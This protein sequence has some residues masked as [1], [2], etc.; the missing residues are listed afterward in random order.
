[1]SETIRCPTT[2]PSTAASG[3]KRRRQSIT[4]HDATIVRRPQRPHNVCGYG[5][6]CKLCGATA[7]SQFRAHMECVFDWITSLTVRVRCYYRAECDQL[8]SRV[9]FVVLRVCSHGWHSGIYFEIFV[10]NNDKSYNCALRSTI[11]YYITPNVVQITVWNS[12]LPIA[13][14]QKRRI[15]D[16][17]IPY[18]HVPFSQANR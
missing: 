18:K 8:L 17:E 4:T 12:L 6:Q 7:E 2:T 14:N 15:T 5:I 3:R 16:H 1:M 9:W 13:H 10:F 11:Y